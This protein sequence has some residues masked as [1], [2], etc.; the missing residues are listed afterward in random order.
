MKYKIFVNEIKVA[1]DV[2]QNVVCHICHKIIEPVVKPVFVIT[3]HC[4]LWPVHE[5]CIKIKDE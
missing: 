5:E 1:V 4:S 3:S 2:E